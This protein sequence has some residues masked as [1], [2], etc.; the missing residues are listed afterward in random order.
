MLN[1]AAL[2]AAVLLVAWAT[3]AAGANPND[4][5][6]WRRRAHAPPLPYPHLLK[7]QADK[8]LP[9]LHLRRR[10]GSP[11]TPYPGLLY[12]SAPLALPQGFTMTVEHD[13]KGD[14]ATG[15]SP[16]QPDGSPSPEPPPA[17]SPLNFPR[18]VADR[19]GACWRPAN[20]LPGQTSEI[21]VR[22]AFSA[23]G[24]VIGAPAVTY[25]KAARQQDQNALRASILE[26]VKD[27]TPLRFTSSLGSAIAGRI[28]A[29][30]F[31]AR[32]RVPPDAPS[33]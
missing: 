25:V 26:A 28:F 12:P 9:R 18:D 19:I 20:P 23:A 8:A 11:V 32:Y 30:R 5:R 17:D 31:I 33:L 7:P 24:A 10:H 13:V 6:H 29:I 14:A 21:T 4:P 16:Q 2:I 15:A 1:R 22:M 27:C 3:D